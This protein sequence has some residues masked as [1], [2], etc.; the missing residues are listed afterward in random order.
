MKKP[1]LQKNVLNLKFPAYMFCFFIALLLLSFQLSAQKK[2]AKPTKPKKVKKIT[3]TPYVPAPLFTSDE[4]LHFTLTGKLREIFSDRADQGVSYHPVLMQFKRKDST[5]SV[6]LMVRSRGHF[7]RKEENCAMAPLMLNFEKVAKL[8]STVFEKQDK[9]K[10]VTPCKNDD[11]VIREYLVYKIYNLFTPYSFKARLAQVE[12]QDSLKKR[13]TETRYCILIEDEVRMAK[14]NSMFLWDKKMVYAEALRRDEFTCTAM[15]QYLIGN[16]DWSVPYLHNIKLL[17][18]DSS[19]VPLAIPYDFDH[20]GIV[21]AP[22]ALP[23]EQLGIS[24]VRE[25]IYRGYCQDKSAFTEMI[26]LFNKKKEDIYKVYTTC[27][28]LDARYIKN[29]VRY[30][31]EFYKTIN[32]PRD[33][34]RQFSDPCRKKERVIIKGYDE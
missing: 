14:R 19:S 3:T 24:S 16:T 20:S 11:H 15:F 30:L 23:P 18:K 13:K 27:A 26:A 2:V 9:L 21:D 17:Y 31:D 32:N 5:V 12:F 7:R 10:L 34:E 28:L 1:I 29:T 8:K 4:V 6:P 33:A 25:R 22:Y